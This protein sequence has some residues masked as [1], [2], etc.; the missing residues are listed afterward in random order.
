MW[1]CNDP[2]TSDARASRSVY[3]HILREASAYCPFTEM[4]IPEP[5]IAGRA[6][7]KAL[8]LSFFYPLLKVCAV[9]PEAIANDSLKSSDSKQCINPYPKPPKAPGISICGYAFHLK[10]Q[11]NISI[12][13]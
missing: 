11:T 10:P 7:G 12:T 1:I 5:L 2:P 6:A 4:G 13:H 8:T 9:S 3:V